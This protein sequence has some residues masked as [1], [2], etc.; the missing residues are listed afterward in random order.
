MGNDTTSP[1]KRCAKCDQF[2]TRDLFSRHKKTKDGLQPYCKQCN[3]A[4]KESL[5]K[6]IENERAQS[7][8]RDPHTHFQQCT[9]CKTTKPLTAFSL[10]R[11]SRNGYCL[12]CKNCQSLYH[13]NHPVRD[14]ERS[15]RRFE[16]EG[17]REQRRQRNRA[18][19]RKNP[20]QHRAAVQ[21]HRARKRGIGGHFTAKDVANMHAI[22]QGHCCYCGR[23]DQVLTIEHIIP[24]TRK[25]SSND[26]W[27]LALACQKCNSSKGDKTLDEWDDPW[28]NPK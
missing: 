27:N 10:D 23:L 16:D 24:I 19:H 7:L 13:K 4:D 8:L 3:K 18:R 28:Y 22:Q 1:L 20:N 9:H 25:G 5:I 2:K 6:V 26:P 12:W 15:R 21:L 11:Q 17:K 14:I